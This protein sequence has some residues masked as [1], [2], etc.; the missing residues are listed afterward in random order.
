MKAIALLAPLLLALPVALPFATPQGAGPA[1][2]ASLPLTVAEASSYARTATSAE[3]EQFVAACAAASPRV[4]RLEMA[5]STKGAAVPLVLVAEPPCPT[6]AAARASGKLA[7]LVCANIH[8]GEVEGKE[9]V[10]ALLRELAAGQ[11][12]ELLERLVLAFVPNLNPDGNDALDRKNRP[13]QNGPV[14]GVGQRANGQGLDLNR[15]FVKL[16]APET[17]GLVAAVNALDA[18]LV[19]DLH[20]TDGSFHG[21]DLTYAAPLHPAT[22]PALFAFAQGT[23]LPALRATMAGAGFATYDYGDFVDAKRPEAGF[24]TF[25]HR[26]RYGTNYFGLCHRLTLLSE[27]YSHESFERRIAATGAFVRAALRFA[28]VRADELAALQRD[29][30]AAGARLAGATELPRRAQLAVTRARDAVLV[31]ECRSEPDPVT[32]L[33]RVIDTGVVRTVEMPVQV[34]FAGLEPIAP[35]AFGWALPE[36]SAEVEALLRRHAIDCE[37]LAAPRRARGSAWRIAKRSEAAR[38]FQGHRLVELE[39][40]PEEWS[41]LLPI[42]TLFVPAKQPLAALALLLLDPRSDDGLATWGLIGGA[43]ESGPPG[44]AGEQ[45]AVLRLE[46]PGS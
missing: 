38:P 20:T 23:F 30:R 40:A 35:P 32:G 17:R 21:Y 6:L 27:A 1:A 26:A 13:D 25:D 2:P 46:Q 16:A 41:G 8:A 31:G 22:D 11:H 24:A 18:A 29:A 19:L 45:F 37:R 33:L 44:A 10:L 15:D 5:T 14:E 34:T 3:V 4:V 43:A 39:G 12:A 36:A 42:G 9:A 28:A 7:V